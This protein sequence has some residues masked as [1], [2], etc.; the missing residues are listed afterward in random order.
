MTTARRLPTA[1]NSGWVIGTDRPSAKRMANG[2]KDR[3]SNEEINALVQHGY[4]VARNGYRRFTGDRSAGPGQP[5]WAPIPSDPPTTRM[6][7]TKKSFAPSAATQ[8]SRQ[9]RRSSRRR[10]WSTLLDPRDW[11]S[12]VYILIALGLFGY[13]PLQVYRLY[14]R[15]QMQATVIDAI[16]NGD[17]DFHEILG[18]LNTDPTSN[19][20]T[21]EIGERSEPTELDYSGFEILTH[22][23]LLDLRNWNPDETLPERQGRVLLRD[24]LTFK[25]VDSASS[26]RRV[27]FRNVLPIEDA[28]FRQ[29]NERLQAAVTKVKKTLEL[30]DGRGTAYEFEYDLSRVP[31]GEPVTIEIAALARLPGLASGRAPFVLQWKTDLLSMWMLFP[32][33][34][35]YRTYSLVK[36]PVD[37]SA[38]P[39]M[40]EPRSKIDHPYGSLIGWSVVN[41]QVGT[42]YEC[43][44][45]TKQ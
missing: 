30:F 42:A 44:W 27:T 26:R 6:R 2:S 41:P 35:P 19:W 24:R 20:T 7:F 14:Q 13:L 22:S 34:R 39:Q 32:I 9:L 43:R 31:F 4:E 1:T 18:L 8:L 12:Y 38:P 17:P 37:K 33:N 25:L 45:T 21:I 3:F 10:V 23:R 5:P 29:P 36:Y 28:E 16:A 40:V 15:A 11:T